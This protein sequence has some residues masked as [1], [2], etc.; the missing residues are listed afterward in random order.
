[1]ASNWAAANDWYQYYY[2][3]YGDIAGLDSNG[4]GIPCESLPGAP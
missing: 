4:D 1:V 3:T 2:P